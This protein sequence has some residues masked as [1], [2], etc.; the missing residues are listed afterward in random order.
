MQ[1]ILA[2][3]IGGTHSRFAAF[4]LTADGNLEKRASLWLETGRSSS[5][6]DLL[7]ELD[8]AGFPLQLRS[9]EAAVFAVAGPVTAENRSR[10]PNIDWPVD[11]TTVSDL[12]DLGRCVLINDFVAQAFAC[13][14]PLGQNACRVLKGVINPRAPLAVFG[15]GTGLGQAALVPLAAGGYV[16]LPSEGG[17]GAFPFETGPEVDY[18]KFLLQETG[19][20]YVRTETVLSGR[21]LSRLHRYLTGERKSAAEVAEG[22]S[23]DSETLRW[24]ATFFGRTARNLA[25]HYLA[26]GGVYASGGLAAKLPKLL[27]HPAFEQAFRC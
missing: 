7:K 8:P 10:P 11:L 16:A 27:T 22:M 17:H 5:F 20:P 15:A 19:E 3:D 25:L 23:P 24:M 6:R 21:G 9:A 12:L 26:F 14:S 13:R 2:A 18:L 4:A 1:M